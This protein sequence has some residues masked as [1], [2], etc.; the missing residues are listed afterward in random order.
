MIDTM[1][2]IIIYMATMLS[3]FANIAGLASVGI[4][5]FQLTHFSKPPL[6]QRKWNSTMT[7]TA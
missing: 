3:R 1:P 5:L 7:G 2:P 4:I 6:T